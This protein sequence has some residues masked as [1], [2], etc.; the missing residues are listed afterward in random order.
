MQDYDF[1][2]IGAGLFNIVLAEKLSKRN[3]KILIIEKRNHI[4]GNCFDERDSQTKI[5][6]HKY[7]P[8]ILHFDNYKI[9]EYLSNFAPFTPFHH[10][11]LTKYQD[12]LYQMPI[13]LETINSFYGLSLTPSEVRNFLEGKSI[14]DI[15]NIYSNVEDKC[16]SMIG[17]ELYNAFFKEYT[18]KQWGQD[19][20]LLPSEIIN[21]IPVRTDYNTSYYN[22]KYSY[23][24]SQGFTFTFEK[25]ISNPNIS[26][27]L[28]T[29]WHNLEYS[30]Y[31]NAIKIYTGAIDRYFDYCYGELEYRSLEFEKEYI[32]VQDYQ[33]ISVVNYPEGKYQWTRICEPRHFYPEK[34]NEYSKTSTVIFKEKPCIDNSEP[35]YP[36]NN[37]KNHDLLKKYENLACKEENLFFG[38][39]LGEYKYFDMEGTI[40]AAFQ[41]Y[42]ELEK[43][44]L[45]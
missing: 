2:L 12:K 10:R 16:I 25:M 30:K 7:G 4:G 39:R 35:Y 1:I 40:E 28:N 32:S 42:D 43:K 17:V 33:G 38:G 24:P 13:N 11:V 31:D 29:N 20:K 34:W 41:L 23:L 14:K 8:H 27:Q 36:I 26:I 5:I 15:E 37:K 22:K 45:I 21:R 3:K 9:Y 19:P 18:Q 6:T 44:C